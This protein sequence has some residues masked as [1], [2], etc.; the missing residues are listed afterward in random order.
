M[1]E[2]GAAYIATAYESVT[3]WLK[4]VP[5]EQP[6]AVAFSGGID[7]T[8]VLLMAIRANQAIGGSPD[9]IRAF[10]LDLGGE[11]WVGGRS[12]TVFTSADP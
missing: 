4:T 3:R 6:V 8:A 5:D 7:S 1:R 12:G 9:R 2:A 10:T 11:S